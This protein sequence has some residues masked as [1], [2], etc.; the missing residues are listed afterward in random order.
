MDNMQLEKERGIT[1]AAKYTAVSYKNATLH[2]VDTPGH[3]DFGGE[4][5]RALELVDG[6]LLVVDPFEGVMTQTKFVVRKALQ[7]GL[8]PLVVLNKV[9]RD[10]VTRALCDAVESDLFDLFAAMGADD[11]QLDFTVVYASARAG[12]ASTSLEEAQKQ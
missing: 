4:V 7:K 10:G 5:E 6:A 12:V 8:K 2:I 3:A 1:I 11:A 9:D